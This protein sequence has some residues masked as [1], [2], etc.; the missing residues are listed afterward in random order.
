MPGPTTSTSTRPTPRTSAAAASL[1]AIPATAA[2]ST[3]LSALGRLPFGGDRLL[4]ELA[5]E[6]ER[7]QPDGAPGDV[8]RRLA[9]SRQ[10]REA[11]TTALGVAV[12][13]TYHALYQYHAPGRPLRPHRDGDGY[14]LVFHLVV[15]Q[16]GSGSVLQVE[17]CPEPWRP[18]PGEG[19]VLRGQ[20]AVHGW[21]TLAPDERRT[22]VAVGFTIDQPHDK[23]AGMPDERPDTNDEETELEDLTPEGEEAEDV[24]G[25]ATLLK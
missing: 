14:P 13:P 22:L 4:A 7:Q 15:A 3:A 8:L 21:T 23:G 12:V 2:S 16:E 10:L 24:Q 18:S 17:G 11:V 5:A 6:A 20:E 9:V 1:P 25:G 19:F